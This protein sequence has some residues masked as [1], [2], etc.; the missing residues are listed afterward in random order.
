MHILP[1]AEMA[2][3]IRR[4]TEISGAV[5]G[6]PMAAMYR[7]RSSADRAFS[8]YRYGKHLETPLGV[9][10]GPHTQ[11]CQNIISAWLCGARYMELKTVQV[12]DKL[13]IPRPCID[14]EDV[15]YNCE[16]SQELTLDDSF[17]QYSD[18]W[19]LLHALKAWLAGTGKYVAGK[20]VNAADF[21]LAGDGGSKGPGF[22][23]NMSVG[24]DLKG[25]RSP[26]VRM[27]MDRMRDGGTLIQEKLASIRGIFSGVG[28]IP[29]SGSISDN[30][31][32]S[33]MHGCPPGEIEKIG[34]YLLEE[35]FHTTI[36]LN[37][38][39]LGP[40]TLRGILNDRLGYS[41][42]VPDAAFGHD[43]KW[44]DALDIIRGLK[45]LAGKNDISFGVKLSNTMEC[46]NNRNVFPPTEK[47]M[48]LSG[49]ALFPL[50]L[51]LAE[52]LASAFKGDLDISFAGGVDCDSFPGLVRAGLWPVTVCSDILR[53]GGYMRLPQYLRNL[54]S[55][56]GA[57]A[58]ETKTADSA[59][60]SVLTAKTEKE[61]RYNRGYYETRSVK[62]SRS[63]N[64]FDCVAAPCIAACPLG[65]RVPEY[66]GAL[67]AGNPEEAVAVIR[68]DNPVA[69]VCA[70]VCERPCER[71][72]TRLNYDRALAIRDLKRFA[73]A[74]SSEPQVIHPKTGGNAG[75]AAR[76]KAAVIGAGP[77]GIACA[78]ELAAR[79]VDVAVFDSA[80]GAGGMVGRVIPPYRIR[81]A[82]ILRDV[83]RLKR[84]GVGFTFNTTISGS[85]AEAMLKSG[86]DA[87]FIAT[88]APLDKDLGLHVKNHKNAIGAL[89]FL[90]LTK[91]GNLYLEN[92]R[93][94]IVGGG[95]SAMD[96]ARSAIRLV[97]PKGSVIL[98]YRRKIIHMP[99]DREEL[100]A[101]IEE[102]VE[103]Q[104]L[105]QPVAF[106]T[107]AEEKVGEKTSTLRCV[108]MDLEGKD[109]SG[110]PAP[111]PVPGSEFELPADLLIYAIGQDR[112]S[113]FLKEFGVEP[114]PGKIESDNPG[115]F[116]G[117]DAVR[118]PSNVVLSAADGREAARKMLAFMDMAEPPP[119]PE[120]ETA[121]APAF[122]GIPDMGAWA[123]GS[124]KIADR[125]EP[126]NTPL[127]ERG[128][129][130]L[131]IGELTPDTALM[132]AGRCLRCDRICNVCVTVCPNRANFFYKT[133]PARYPVYRLFSVG[134]GTAIS[135]NSSSPIFK[136][137][138]WF[139]V[140]QGIQTAHI[141][142]FCNNCGNCTTFCPSSGSP[143]RDK[144][145]ICLTE[146]SFS[147]EDDAY[148]FRAKPEPCLIYKKDGRFHSFKEDDGMY[149]YISD[150]FDVFF[151]HS[152]MEITE[153]AV[154]V[155]QPSRGKAGAAAMIATD[156]AAVMAFLFSRLGPTHIF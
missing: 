90:E 103:I 58:G 105:V 129:S 154:T 16:W 45:S 41:V 155:E 38:T 153:L 59:F 126:K 11:L 61:S 137:E 80:A 118:G 50:T 81:E 145:R 125:V 40:D 121:I 94:V 12:L 65:Q 98:L 122:P 67:S 124:G 55:E 27:F 24:Y 70:M 8:F 54:E 141:A 113:A 143:F 104:E 112:D 85:E 88:G 42:E 34:R 107:E 5:F 144:P 92:K 2:R 111:V 66:I 83:E 13:D 106:L 114:R 32:L 39:L 53:P 64:A 89:K 127:A 46:V 28:E 43:L 139:E 87:M 4:E 123:A 142:D 63:L 93:V 119:A 110:R 22:I 47:M 15:G 6:I 136:Q 135:G 33:T 7:S 3:R 149:H 29:I 72:C 132:E 100:A 35:G 131:V 77:A 99:A 49:R 82:D 71:A 130:N 128:S 21:S 62:N 117:G 23:F 37:P 30:V 102:G 56:E 115:I 133:D 148:L 150:P 31:T 116:F 10:A 69:A 101:I 156:K 9:A 95:N 57:K 36:K 68:R 120:P 44:A 84:A 14:M 73:L 60:L 140:R 152:T 146:E 138:G 51:T 91:H 147:R 76:K 52:K 25:I 79:G 97:G 48:Y 74:S 20:D 151:N 96:A 108:R 78:W 75:V 86:Y 134:D 17:R 18:A 26:K 1:I 109:G 19:V